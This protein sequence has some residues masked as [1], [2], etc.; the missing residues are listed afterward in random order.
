MVDIKDIDESKVKPTIRKH[1]PFD[2]ER[3]EGCNKDKC[4]HE[5][6]ADMSTICFAKRFK[7]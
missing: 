3:E 4:V 6:K 5:L 1:P 7:L 2:R